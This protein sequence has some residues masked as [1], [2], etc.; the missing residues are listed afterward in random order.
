MRHNTFL[1]IFFSFAAAVLLASAVVCYSQTNPAGN[2]RITLITD[3]TSYSVGDEI[4]FEVVFSNTGDMPFRILIDS[5]FIGSR[6]E[7]TDLQDRLYAPEGGYD[8]WSP[9][10]GVYNGRTY[11]LKP[12]ETK[13]VRMDAL[14][15][16]GYKLIFSNL[17]DRTGY[18]G[19]KEFK[20][21]IHLPAD[22]PDKY[23]SAGMIFSLQEK[24]SCRF[25]YIYEITEHDKHWR[26][27]G[28]R[29]PAEVSVDLLWTGKAMSNTIEIQI[30]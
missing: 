7:C 14:V 26:F 18:T 3:T 28:A 4:H 10:A 2:L 25:T 27:T 6:M 22:F 19:Y 11:L 24:D 20:K 23:L 16:D 8:S 30:E 17:F 5:V 29:T 13:T 1:V 9:K 15:Y 12:N 21:R